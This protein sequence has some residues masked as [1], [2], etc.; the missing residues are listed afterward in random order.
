MVV[1]VGIAGYLSVKTRWTQNGILLP[2]IS[3]VGRTLLLYFTRIH[4]RD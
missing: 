3:C 1:T 2:M 4:V